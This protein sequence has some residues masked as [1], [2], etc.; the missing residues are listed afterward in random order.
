[1]VMGS[2]PNHL[3]FLVC[4]LVLFVYVDGQKAKS[5]HWEKDRQRHLRPHNLHRPPY[6]DFDWYRNYN[7]DTDPTQLTHPKRTKPKS[8]IDSSGH[9]KEGNHTSES[10]ESITKRPSSAKKKIN[11]WT[12]A[13]K[14]TE[15]VIQKIF[16]RK[17]PK[18]DKLRVLKDFLTV[19][20]V[21]RAV[22]DK[23]SITDAER[24]MLTPALIPLIYKFRFAYET[25]LDK[26]AKAARAFKIVEEEA[27][28]MLHR[29]ED[30]HSHTP[31]SIE[32]S[33]TRRTGYKNVKL[34]HYEQAEKIM[35]KIFQRSIPKKDMLG[36]LKK[37]LT[38][39]KVIDAVKDR[40]FITDDE[41]RKLTPKLIAVV[42]KFK[43]AYAKDFE[44]HPK[45]ARAFKI[46]YD[47]AVKISQSQADKPEPSYK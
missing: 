3:A 18:K 15:E 40:G 7:R 9:L 4:L 34:H 31:E 14:Q 30:K 32:K 1:M 10:I 46:V 16:E 25:H 19:A 29:H 28:K 42:F 23:G 37:I 22:K 36:V 17:I 44:E 26:N 13:G 5:N 38:V 41:R 8:T 11:G 2:S 45:A 39:V 21:I 43:D 27:I 35:H 6:K 33:G 12:H 47:E 24:A 20:K